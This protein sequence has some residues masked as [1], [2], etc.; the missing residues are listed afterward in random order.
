MRQVMQMIQTKYVWTI[1][2]EM[3]EA[4]DQVIFQDRA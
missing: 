1:L 4:V 2:V 3:E